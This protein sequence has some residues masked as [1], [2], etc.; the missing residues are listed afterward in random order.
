VLYPPY[1]LLFILF[2]LINLDVAVIYC[3]LW[4]FLSKTQR[5]CRQTPT[6][7]PPNHNAYAAKPQRLCRQTTTPM[8]QNHNRFS[9]LLWFV[10]FAV[11][12]S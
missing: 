2:L 9:L 6:P 3:F 11:I 12:L 4:F 8:P 5:L 10:F 7:M 1:S